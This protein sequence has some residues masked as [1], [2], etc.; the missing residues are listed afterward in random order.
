MAV[1]TVVAAVIATLVGVG[2]SYHDGALK[3]TLRRRTDEAETHEAA[4]EIRETLEGVAED[5]KHTRRKVDEVD[6]KVD[7]VDD[8]VVG[9]HD[10]VDDVARSITIMHANDPNVNEDD[11]RERLDV[12]RTDY[13]LVEE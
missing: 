7:D 13:D 2:K 5:V 11:L 3:G 8:K 10:R 1:G 9:A 4:P 6:S 12:D